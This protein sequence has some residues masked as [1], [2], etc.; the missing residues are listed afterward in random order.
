MASRIMARYGRPVAVIGMDGH[1]GRGSCRSIDAVNILDGLEACSDLLM[2][3]GGHAMAAGLELQADHLEAFK[4]R[5]NEAVAASIRGADLR[6]VM[7]INRQI[8]LEDAD[9][10]LMD[11][12][13]RTGPFGQ[14]NP[15][16]IWA[17]C[18][19]TAVDS[20]I[21]KEKHLKVILSDG[22]SR[23]EAI[24]FNLAD[25]LPSGPVDVAFTLHENNWN[26]R[27]SIQLNIRYIR[28][29]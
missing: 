27:T 28:P 23:R 19:V 6:P 12:L 5:F 9:E 14:D 24:G 29:A 15:E 13:K 21:L 7:E 25:Q 16:P 8:S 2:Q 1:T 22:K 20:R 10:M 4:I 17:V 3:F 11:G 18:N 26:G